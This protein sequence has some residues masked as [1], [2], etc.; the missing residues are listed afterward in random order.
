MGTPRRRLETEHYAQVARS[1]GMSR[2]G[3]CQ[4]Y[5]GVWARSRAGGR[6]ENELN[7]GA[8]AHRSLP[9]GL[10]NRHRDPL[11][12]LARGAAREPHLHSTETA[13]G[14]NAARPTLELRDGYV[15]RCCSRWYDSCGGKNDR[16]ASERVSGA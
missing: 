2:P 7:R 9:A 3:K 15:L 4:P 13:G 12:P 6:F 16:P 5:P 10:P 14:N 1:M 11:A 8:H